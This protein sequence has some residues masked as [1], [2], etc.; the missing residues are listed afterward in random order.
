MV[1]KINEHHQQVL[2]QLPHE[3]I[4]E[5]AEGRG[6]GKKRGDCFL[7]AKN[8]HPTQFFS[9]ERASLSS[10][11]DRLWRVTQ[12]LSCVCVYECHTGATVQTN[13]K[14]AEVKMS[15]PRGK[16]GFPRTS[17]PALHCRQID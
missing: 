7:A 4:E 2:S 3:Q 6:Q 13:E 5:Q 14:V 9:T 11:I 10:M 8:S 1:I 17:I 12:S 15:E 16:N